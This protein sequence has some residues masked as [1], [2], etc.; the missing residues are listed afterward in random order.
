MRTRTHTVLLP[1]P[2][3]RPRG[4]WGWVGS[5]EAGSGPIRVGQIVSLTGNYSPLGSENQKSVELAVEEINAAG[6]VLGR[7]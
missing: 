3:A 5:Q 4:L 1:A 7:Q 2:H 6:G